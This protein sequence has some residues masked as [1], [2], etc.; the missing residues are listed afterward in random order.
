MGLS[1]KI[2]GRVVMVESARCWEVRG[3][4]GRGG[5]P[6]CQG[7]DGGVCSLLGGPRLVGSR[8]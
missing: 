3:W 2:G 6:W 5:D 7:G 8:W 1:S 4:W